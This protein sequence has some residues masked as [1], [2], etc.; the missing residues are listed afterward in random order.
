ML[1]VMAFVMVMPF[2]WL[3]SSSLK[4][5]IQIFSYP[6]QWIPNPFTGKTSSTP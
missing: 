6:P 3:V 5:Q 1:L 2:V 4:S